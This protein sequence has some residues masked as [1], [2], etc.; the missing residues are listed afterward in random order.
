MSEA[1]KI[2]L[3]LVALSDQRSSGVE[4]FVKNVL[5]RVRVGSKGEISIALRR[6]LP[7]KEALGAQF[8]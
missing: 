1:L 3:N 5:G 2:G 6:T 7:V 4:T 8:I